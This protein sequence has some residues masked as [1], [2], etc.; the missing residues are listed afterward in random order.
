MSE[1]AHPA[2]VG[3]DIL[4]KPFKIILA[5]FGLGAVLILWRYATGLGS[6]TALNDGYPWGIWIA[7]DVV[8]GTALA[9][10][11]YA[12][13]I[14]CYILNKGEYHPLVRP[15]V[16]TS[17]LGYSVAAVA[18][19]VDVGRYWNLYLAALPWKW[20]LNSVLLEVALCVMSYIVVLWIEM[21]PA[22]MEVWKDGKQPF[23]RRASQSAYPIVNKALIWILAL[24]ILLPTMHQSSLGSVFLVSTTKLHKL[25][26]TPLLPLLFLISCIALGY[27]AVVFEATLS[28]IAFKKVRETKML[29]SLSGVMAIVL[30]IYLGIRFLDLIFRGRLGLMF[31]PDLYA[32]FFWIEVVLFAAPALMLMSKASRASAGN[33]FRAAILMM[34]AGVLYR[35]DV[36]LIGYN[37]GAGWSYFPSIPEMLI[38]FG[39]VSLE[40]MAYIYIVK[41]FPVLAGGTATSSPR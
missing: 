6:V 16:L 27:A 41:R 23:L 28:S 4:T 12:V 7:F 37:P 14:L 17:A 8:A 13:A 36:Y 11:G 1:H 3:G 24:G 29:A 18:I 21:S 26:H 2:P 30:A 22:F 33:Q 31:K 40:I 5:I 32:L 9:C 38:T 39:V 15:A 35:F 19:A 10:G 20:N 34:L 25:W